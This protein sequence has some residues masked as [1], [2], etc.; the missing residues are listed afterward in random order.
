MGAAAGASVVCA[1]IKICVH[2]FFHLA[3]FRAIINDGRTESDFHVINKK[4]A[5]SKPRN[6]FE[7]QT[8]THTEY[9]KYYFGHG[10]LLFC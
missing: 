5:N 4:C 7:R 2:E 3:H 6:V 10:L 9:R 1:S 8:N